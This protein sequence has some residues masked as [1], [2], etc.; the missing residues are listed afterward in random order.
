MG[1]GRKE[2]MGVEGAFGK[3]DLHHVHVHSQPLPLPPGRCLSLQPPHPFRTDT[4]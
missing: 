3:A 4:K 2:G 1:Q